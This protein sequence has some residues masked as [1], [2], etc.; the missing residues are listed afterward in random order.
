MKTTQ[1]LAALIIV[2][3]AAAITLSGMTALIIIQAIIA[4]AGVSAGVYIT[5]TGKQIT[6]SYG[7]GKEVRR[8]KREALRA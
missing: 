5:V 3:I 6:I 2:I 8:G 7:K 1:K 4:V